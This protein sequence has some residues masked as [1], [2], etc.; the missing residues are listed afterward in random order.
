MKK[1]LFSLGLI[2]SL[3]FVEIKVSAQA[4]VITTVAAAQGTNLVLASACRLLTLSILSAGAQ[5]IKFYDMGVTNTLSI[6]NDTYVSRI[7]YMTNYTNVTAAGSTA[8][9]VPQTNVFSGRWTQSV[10]NAA[11]TNAVPIIYTAIVGSG[12]PFYDDSVNL[13]LQRGLAEVSTVTT[14]VTISTKT[15]P[16]IP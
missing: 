12:I 6:T 8:T 9:G 7:S 11:A 5:T 16:Y 4:T 14:N 1:I 13:D 2:G 10:T 3:L 15:I